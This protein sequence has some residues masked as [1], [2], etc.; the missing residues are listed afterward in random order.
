LGKGCRND[1]HTAAS[2]AAAEDRCQQPKQPP[3]LRRAHEEPRAMVAECG[4][5]DIAVTRR[6]A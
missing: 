4:V 2:A 5:G 3:Q 6:N 1:M